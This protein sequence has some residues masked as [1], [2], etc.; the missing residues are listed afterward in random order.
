MKLTLSIQI[1]VHLATINARNS[2]C[3]SVH[4]WIVCVWLGIDHENND[5]GDPHIQNIFAI[6]S[7]HIG[8]WKSEEEEKNG[9]TVK[10][11]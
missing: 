7:P 2:L 9:A 11:Q 5:F 6:R 10:R 1:R 8:H 4:M 3:F